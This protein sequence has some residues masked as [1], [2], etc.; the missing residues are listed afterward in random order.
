MGFRRG[1]VEKILT[2]GRSIALLR[3]LK[4]R[5][6]RIFSFSFHAA[7]LSAL[8]F[9]PLVFTIALLIVTKSL[10]V[11]TKSLLIVTKSLLI[12]TKPLLIVS[13]PLLISTKSD[14][15]STKSDIVRTKKAI[16]WPQSEEAGRSSARG[17]PEGNLSLTASLYFR[18][19]S[20]G[21]ERECETTRSI[22]R[23]GLRTTGLSWPR[24][25]GLR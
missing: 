3:A 2:P 14:L 21:S 15:I 17:N 5:K 6:I 11:F 10:L 1:K 18:A 7:A 22:P 9:S 19:E 4:T 25:R 13:K 16:V 23:N 24:G 12:V 8:N 20:G